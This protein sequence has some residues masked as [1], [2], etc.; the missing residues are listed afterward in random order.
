MKYGIGKLANYALR[1]AATVLVG[2]SLAMPA[3]AQVT[4]RVG[5]TV[6]T[7][8][9]AAALA[10]AMKKGA[11]KKAGLDIELKTFVQSNQKYDTF[12]A[13]AIDMDVNMGAINAA[14]L[15][16]AGVPVVVLRAATPADIWAVVARPD[17]KL[18]TP[19]DFKGKRFGV[20]SLSGTNFGATYAAFKLEKVDFMRDVKVSTL[21]P[22]ALLLALD[23][24]E[25][26]GATIY[27][28]YLTPALKS[29]RVKVVFKPGDVY[30]QYYKEPFLA[31]VISAQKD[32]VAKNRVAAAK[33]VSI[34]EETMAS[35]GDNTDQAAQAMIEVMPDIKLSKAEIKDLLVPYIPNVI[36][37]PNTPQT[38]KAAQSLYDRMLEAKQIRE[39]V[40]ASDFWIKL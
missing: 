16:G 40:K 30:Q 36:K 9:S 17:S 1:A 37:T 33:F 8:V 28:P 10:L 3:A 39:P 2:A 24:G 29:G 14:Q 12:K 15:F 20:V 19:S 27:E 25:I 22:S 11:F 32:F 23:K 31:L 34:M 21:P 35:L 4:I 6:S 5:S 13:G 7:D 38:V 18:K 26:D